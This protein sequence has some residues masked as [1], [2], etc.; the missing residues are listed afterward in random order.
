MY[1]MFL[2]TSTVS[3]INLNY[4]VTWLSVFQ[5]C[6]WKWNLGD[7]DINFNSSDFPLISR[8]SGNKGRHGVFHYLCFYDALYVHSVFRWTLLPCLSVVKPCCV[9]SLDVCW[10]CSAPLCYHQT[11]RQMFWSLYGNAGPDDNRQHSDPQLHCALRAR[12]PH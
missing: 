1:S 4:S 3:I 6:I 8:F 2:I 7:P 5:L 10:V 12:F 9:V 11:N